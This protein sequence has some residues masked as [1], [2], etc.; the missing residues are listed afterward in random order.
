MQIDRA[1]LL[2]AFL[3]RLA[4]DTAI[5]NFILFI[6]PLAGWWHYIHNKHDVHISGQP[7]GGKMGKVE[8][9]E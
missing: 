3:R 7:F 4:N 6:V 2:F 9:L 5:S 8:L 1:E